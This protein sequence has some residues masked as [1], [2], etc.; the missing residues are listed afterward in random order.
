MFFIIRR[1]LSLN[2]SRCAFTL[3]ELLVVIAIIG[4]LIALLLPAVQAAREAARRTQCINNLKNI[5]LA[6]HSHLSAQRV[7]PAG[8]LGC[9]TWT[10]D[11]CKGVPLE[12][13]VGTSAFVAI[14]PYMEQQPLYDQF[15]IHDFK[16]GPWLTVGGGGFTTWIPDYVDAIGTRLSILVCPSDEAEPC[17]E[18]LPNGQVMGGGHYV[19]A[20]ICAATGSYAPNLGTNGP[21]H[22]PFTDVK[23]DNTGAFVYIRSLRESEFTDGLSSTLFVGEAIETSSLNS[24][25]VWSLAYR[26]LS[27]RTTR[28]PINTPPGKGAFLSNLHSRSLNGAFQSQH[29]GGS[30]FLFG[31]GHVSLVGENIDFVTYNAL[32]TRAGGETISNFE[33]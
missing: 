13:R 20:G 24:G 22:S 7:F 12:N 4:V 31:D 11:S 3:V 6:I 16:N 30:Q 33:F 5:G 21:P 14:L 32:A 9:D 8:R 25:I 10:Q 17:C 23:S 26:L 1:L 28:N 19:S 29:P 2:S 18:T 27:L 15:S